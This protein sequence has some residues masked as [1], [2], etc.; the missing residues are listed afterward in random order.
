MIADLYAHDKDAW[1]HGRGLTEET[2]DRAQLGY[3]S[4][5]RYRDAIVIPYFD[6]RGELRN[7]RYR[8]LRHNP[9]AKYESPKGFGTHLYNVAA[10]Q[11]DVVAI[12]EGEFDALVLE[13]L[14]FSAV[15]IPG[16]NTWQREWRWLFRDC[17]LVLVV[18]DMA[19]TREEDADARAAEERARARIAAQVGTVTSCEVV[20]LPDGND[21]TD[22]Y[23][24]DP[25]KLKELLA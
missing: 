6:A 16:V 12:C 2:I 21:V 13:Q 18:I 5:G 25:D 1:L 19:S 9:P 7:V 15:A 23:L 14:G 10:T 17:D 3:Q 8:H 22:L 11:N 4:S 24:T 20:E